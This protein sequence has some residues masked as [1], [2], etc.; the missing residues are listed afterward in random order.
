MSRKTYRY[1]GD[2]LTLV[3]IDGVPVIPEEPTET[4]PMVMYDLPGY[5]SPV[6]GK[7]VE[8]RA[9]RREDLKR[10]GCRPYEGRES[11][12]KEVA[13]VRAAVAVKTDQL[14]EKMA[15]KAW[16]DAPERTRRL[17]RGK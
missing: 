2:T 9:A 7:W 12:A 13:K 17:F 14:A 15:R 8:G 4:G 10:T 5:E 16:N 1:I 3:K 6:S 11:E